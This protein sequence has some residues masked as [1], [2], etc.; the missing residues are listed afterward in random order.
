MAAMAPETSFKIFK[1]P[2]KYRT[3]TLTSKICILHENKFEEL[4][5]VLFESLF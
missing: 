2:W 4:T 3:L 5:L 1:V